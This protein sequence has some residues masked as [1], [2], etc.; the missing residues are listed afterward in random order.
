MK[1]AAGPRKPTTLMLKQ[2]TQLFPQDDVTKRQFMDALLLGESREQAII[3]LEDR[4]EIQAFPR[5]RHMEWQPE[6]VERLRPD[7]RPAR[8]PLYEK[9]VF[10]SLDASSALAASTMLAIPVAPKRILD[11]CA[12]PG[13][14]SV[15]AWRAFHPELLVSNEIIRKR[16]PSLI[17]NLDRC[18]IEGSRVTAADPGV[19]GRRFPET[20][21][22]V[23]ADAP[24]SGQSM[25]AK[26]EDAEGCFHANMIDMNV[27]R[28]RR[29]LGNAYQ[30]CRPGGHILYTTCT[31]SLKENERVVEWLLKEYEGQIEAVARPEMAEFQSRYS[32]IPCYR[33]F[34]HQGLGAGMFSCLLRKGGE[35]PEHPASLEGLPGVWVYGR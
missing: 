27:G 9:G 6:F 31:Y 13:G 10:Y 20:F 19:W 33:L 26:G 2:V 7:F 28:Q 24:C 22:L 16:H 21:D 35:I 5:E 3:V 30:A 14:K 4:P 18:H 34:P 1:K 25:L 12:S 17:A 32:E 15:F 11:M 8:H 23:L 29:I